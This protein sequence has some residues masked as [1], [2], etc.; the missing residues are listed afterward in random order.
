MIEDQKKADEDATKAH[1]QEIFKRIDAGAQMDAEEKKQTDEAYRFEYEQSIISLSQYKKFLDQ[2]VRDS[3]DSFDEMMSYSKQYADL[4]KQEQQQIADAV[5]QATQEQQ[6]EQAKQK[7]FWTNLATSVDDV[8]QNAFEQ[9]ID[10]GK[11]F[12]NSL[13]NGLQVALIKMAEDWLTSQFMTLVGGTLDNLFPQAGGAFTKGLHLPGMAIGGAVFGNTPY[14][15]GERGPELF[16]PGASGSIVPNNQLALAG[17]GGNTYI[18]MQVHAN[19][20]SSFHYTESQIGRQMSQQLAY[21][22]RRGGG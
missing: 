18:N 15:V 11:N 21:S 7:K 13:I 3:K 17:G 9:A 12:F 8:F 14:I 5:K 6:Q 10:K 19:D 4:Q 2:R 1:I 16:I 20:A 22:N